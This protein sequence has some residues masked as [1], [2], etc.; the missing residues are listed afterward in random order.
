M[1]VDLG[2]LQVDRRARA[3]PVQVG[4]HLRRVASRDRVTD[5]GAELGVGPAAVVLLQLRRVLGEEGLAQAL[6]G[7]VGERRDGVGAHGEHGGDVGG[8]VALDLGV[9]QHQLPAFGERGERLGCCSALEALDRSVDERHSRVEGLHVVGGVQPRG[10]AEA[11]DL[12]PAYGGEEI[13]AEGDIRPPTALEHTEHLDEGLRD[14]VLGVAGC[15]EL[16]RQATCCLDVALEEGPVGIGVPAADRRDQLGVPGRLNA[17]RTA[18]LRRRTHRLPGAAAPGPSDSSPGRAV[19]TGVEK[20]RENHSCSR[21][22]P[23]ASP[24]YW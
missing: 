8:F 4:V 21:H 15:D 2:E 11:V 19:G 23:R 6:T 9:P 17:G 13:G 1:G 10:G 24:S 3:A 12:E 7:A 18:H 20:V 22:G 14:Q 5:V 16:T